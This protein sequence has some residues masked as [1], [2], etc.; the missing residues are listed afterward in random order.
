[1]KILL[2]S[3]VINEFYCDYIEKIFAEIPLHFS[4][5]I[6]DISYFILLINYMNITETELLT[7]TVSSLT[8][9]GSLSD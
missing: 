4:R 9:D 1:M 5:N 6:M 8:S 3:V 2:I 7:K